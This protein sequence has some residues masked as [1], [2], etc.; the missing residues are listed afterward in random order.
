M[1]R[2]RQELGIALMLCSGYLMAAG[3]VLHAVHGVFA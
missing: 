3:A 2:L 1:S